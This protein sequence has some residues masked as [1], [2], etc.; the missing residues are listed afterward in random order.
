MKLHQLSLFLENKPGQLKIPCKILANAGINIV[1]LSLADTQ[2][3]GILRLIVKDWQK[4][5]QILE[6]AGA[7]VNVTEVLAI[8]VNDQPG[9]LAGI[10]DVLERAN[11][12]IE[13]MYAFTGGP[14]AK[15]AT[16]VFRFENPD[17]A[18]K[19]LNANGINTVA[20]AD[21]FDRLD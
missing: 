17:L 1:T 15:K 5:K 20:S 21:L 16:L 10:L 11:I 6:A 9:G 14:Q 18:L 13:Y 19:A 4:A 2:K 3:F 12:A 8:D 7:V